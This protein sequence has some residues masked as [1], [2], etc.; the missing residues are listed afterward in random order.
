VNG[1]AS[2]LTV[3]HAVTLLSK[4][5]S[6]LIGRMRLPGHVFRPVDVRFLILLSVTLTRSLGGSP[7]FR[8]AGVLGNWRWMTLLNRILTRSIGERFLGG[9]AS[10]PANRRRMTSLCW[11]MS[12]LTVRRLFSGCAGSPGDA[13]FLGLLCRPLIGAIGRRPTGGRAGEPGDGTRYL[14]PIPT[15]RTR[16]VPVR[17]LPRVCGVMRIPVGSTGS[18]GREWRQSRAVGLSAWVSAAM[19]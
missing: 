12:R 14:V 4:T 15:I 7:V 2:I 1:L 9:Y 5:P 17:C 16:F 6:R 11:T 19:G 10:R 13:R 18:G 8:F 3:W